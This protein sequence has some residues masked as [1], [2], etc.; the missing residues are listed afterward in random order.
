MSIPRLPAVTQAWSRACHSDAGPC[1]SA[2]PLS[3]GHQ[4]LTASGLQVPANLVRPA[5]WAS[6][7]QWHLADRGLG[8]HHDADQRGQRGRCALEPWADRGHRCATWHC[9]AGLL[10]AAR[11][12]QHHHSCPARSL[13]GMGL[14]HG[15]IPVPAVLPDTLRLLRLTA[16]MSLCALPCPGPAAAGAVG[17]PVQ[18]APLHLQHAA[19]QPAQPA[20]RC[21]PHTGP[22]HRSCWCRDGVHSVP[23]SPAAPHGRGLHD[24]GPHRTGEVRPCRAPSQPCSLPVGLLACAARAQP[25]CLWPLGLHAATLTH[26]LW[27][28][29]ACGQLPCRASSRLTLAVLRAGPSTWTRA[30]HRGG[31]RA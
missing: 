23:L 19:P 10:H 14:H 1:W 30:C 9:D 16:C 8:R 29:P 22:P 20:E 4:L 15:R 3:V 6:L 25:E 13:S 21:W 31:R 28:P 7:R 24:E 2:A 12:G 27:C 11:A 5:V 17:L 26:R 18:P